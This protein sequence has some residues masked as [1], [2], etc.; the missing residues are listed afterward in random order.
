MAHVDFSAGIGEHFEHII[1]GP[2]V[3]I[4]GF[5]KAI[6]LPEFLPFEFNILKRIKALYFRFIVHKIQPLFAVT[7]KVEL[8]KSKTPVLATVFSKEINLGEYVPFKNIFPFLKKFFTFSKDY[9]RGRDF[10]ILKV[11]NVH[12]MPQICFEIIHPVLAHRYRKTGGDIFINITSDAWFGKR[13]EMMQH[14][15][16]ATFRC[17]ENRAP[18][19][20]VA[21]T[22]IS[23]YISPTGEILGDVSPVDE[24]WTDCRR[25]PLVKTY[26]FYREYGDVFSWLCLGFIVLIFFL[27]HIRRDAIER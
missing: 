26:S 14:L 5:E 19:V 10:P 6:F 3:I 22:G 11:N 16:L 12:I 15:L 9:R 25:V 13:K 23:A 20:R 7:N 24:P 27:K 8:L 4:P 17:I 18:M 1:L 2:R 21:N